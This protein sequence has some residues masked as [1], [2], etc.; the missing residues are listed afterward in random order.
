MYVSEWILSLILLIFHG[1]SICAYFNAKRITSK[2]C[3]SHSTKLEKKKTNMIENTNEKRYKKYRNNVHNKKEEA[4]QNI[5]IKLDML[6]VVVSFVVRL[7]SFFF[8]LFVCDS[9]VYESK[10][11]STSKR[12]CNW[13]I[14]W[15]FSQVSFSP[16][17]DGK[18]AVVVCYDHINFLISLIWSQYS[19]KF[20]W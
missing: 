6:C 19:I 5:I 18:E 4:V 10:S 8:W 7:R 9:F 2:H 13:R 11:G 12:W 14:W 1:Q 3:S 15:N 20:L 17:I 16:L